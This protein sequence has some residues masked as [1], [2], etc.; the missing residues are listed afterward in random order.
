MKKQKKDDWFELMKLIELES[1]KCPQ[2]KS[3]CYM[4]EIFAL[5]E[6]MINKVRIKQNEKTI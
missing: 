6:K 1:E 5:V 2:K 4:N 3:E